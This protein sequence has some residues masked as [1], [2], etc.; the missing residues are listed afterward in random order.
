MKRRNIILLIVSLVLSSTVVIAQEDNCLT[1]VKNVYSAWEKQVK[2]SEGNTVYLKYMT[3]TVTGGDKK[4]KNTSTVEVISNKN[5]AAFLSADLKVY[6]DN[7]NTVSILSDK[8]IIVINQ[9]VGDKY[10]EEKLGQIELL[11]DT[12]FSQL[13]TQECKK[14]MIAN[15]EY[16]K[17]LLKA[18]VDATKNYKINTINFLINPKEKSIKEVV[19]N[20]AKGHQLST[21]KF[22]IIKQDLKYKATSIKKVAL[23]NVLDSNGKILSKYAGYKLMDNR[24]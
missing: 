8:K 24:K 15:V 22:R 10:K 12:I 21:M 9:Y 5:N 16:K 3:E 4:V 23:A 19:I 11:Q 7:K 1:Q 20:Y 18:D 17:V 14:E 2:A 13:K 6:Q